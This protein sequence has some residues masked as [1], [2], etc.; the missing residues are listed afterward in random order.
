MG[1]E[2]SKWG[3]RLC[4]CGERYRPARRG[5]GDPFHFRVMR[6]TSV[7]GGKALLMG[8]WRSGDWN[9]NERLELRR[10]DGTMLAIMDAEMMPAT[11]EATE[12]RGQRTLLVAGHRSLE[13][14]SC[15][16]ASP[17]NDG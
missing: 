7:P 3:E 8:H 13:P 16:W 15:I 10:R 12:L 6:V 14:Q 11:N 4:Q 17:S 9:P 5:Q 1:D 2:Q